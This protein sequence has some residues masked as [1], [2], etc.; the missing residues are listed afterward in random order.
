MTTTKINESKRKTDKSV[1]IRI[2]SLIKTEFLWRWSLNWA[3]CSYNAVELNAFQTKTDQRL[4]TVNKLT[5]HRTTNFNASTV[6]QT[7]HSLRVRMLSTIIYKTLR[8]VRYAFSSICPLFNIYIG[9]FDCADHESEIRFQFGSANT[10][11]QPPEV[12]TSCLPKIKISRNLHYLR[13][14]NFRR[15]VALE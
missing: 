15:I 11:V 1:R 13:S 12:L 5:K 3:C 2:D 10:H 14:S 8:I 7:K 4:C 9:Q 6:L